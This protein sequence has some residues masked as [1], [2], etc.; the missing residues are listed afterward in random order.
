MTPESFQSV[1]LNDFVEA[2]RY[3]FLTGSVVPRPIA[4]VTSV[5]GSGVVN[6]A[7][8]SQ[9]VIVSVTPPMLGIVAHEGEHGQKDTI[10]NI[11]ETGEFVINTVSERMA[12]Q[13]Q[14]CGETF[15]PEVSEVEVVG[16]HT[17]PSSKVRAPR[18]A[19]SLL[20]FECKLHRTFDFGIPESRTM[21]VVGE[22]VTVHCAE[23][24]LSGHRID[25][26][27]FNPLG[28]IAGRSYCKTGDT[29]HV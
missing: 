9:F 14:K 4:L 21:L 19:E 5:G 2:S 12:I 3:K 29:V 28:R 23:G 22:V 1:D 16:F 17:L 25:H 6:A 10:R 24:V 15:P 7:P 27:R 20:H 13:V 8:Y 26:D 18:I 11:L